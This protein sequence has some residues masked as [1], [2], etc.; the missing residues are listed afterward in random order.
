MGW[1]YE[2]EEWTSTLKLLFR[3]YGF[4][5]ITFTILFAGPNNQD[6]D[7][8]GSE[9]NE[10][11]QYLRRLPIQAHCPFAWSRSKADGL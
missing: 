9:L 11:L 5:K 10:T 1:A 4:S 7:I 2:G 6:Y 3:V 8:L